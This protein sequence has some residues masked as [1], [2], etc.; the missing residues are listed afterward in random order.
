M[1]ITPLDIQQQQ[2]KGKLIGGLNPEEVDTFLQ[3]VAREMEELVREN[4][5]LKEHARKA[6]I[7][8][9]ELSQREKELRETLLAAQRVIEE[10]KDNA[11][12]EAGLIVAEAE[13]KADRLLAD[14]E[15]R[16]ILLQNEIRE[17]QRQK[18]QFESSL[19]SLLDSYYKMLTLNEE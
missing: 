2:F 17:L 11:Q 9:E 7:N 15:N 4:N 1:K 19:R 3:L 14:S 5:D 6:S 10:M 12:K 13:I 18:L 16:L 8:Q